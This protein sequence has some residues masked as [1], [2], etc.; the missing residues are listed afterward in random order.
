[1]LY[2]HVNP[3]NV[4]EISRKDFPPPE[5]NR[6]PVFLNQRVEVYLP[7]TLP[8]TTTLTERPAVDRDIYNFTADTSSPPIGQ[9]SYYGERVTSLAFRN[10]ANTGVGTVGD[11]TSQVVETIDWT[12]SRLPIGD[13]Y[14]VREE[15]LRRIYGAVYDQGVQVTLESNGVQDVQ[16]RVQAGLQ[17][18]YIAHSAGTVYGLT[19]GLPG[20]TNYRVPDLWGRFFAMQPSDAAPGKNLP[21]GLALHYTTTNA[22][23]EDHSTQMET[24]RDANNWEG[25]ATYD[26]TVNWPEAPTD[27]RGEQL[28]VTQVQNL[29]RTVQIDTLSRAM[30]HPRIQGT[31]GDV[32]KNVAYVYRFLLRH[33]AIRDDVTALFN[34]WLTEHP[35]A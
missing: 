6:A 17:Y 16:T 34:Q 1:M 32:G 35:G 18:V 26:L 12:A 2:A 30:M 22:V 4:A 14:A 21:V 29:T 24:L 11:A 19:G 25:L 28:S 23:S 27:P 3:A 10:S 13:L 20:I 15:E 9:N 5:A 8:D 31:P 7:K 33:Y